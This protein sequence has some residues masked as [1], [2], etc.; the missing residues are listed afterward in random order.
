VLVP[1]ARVEPRD[2]RIHE[3]AFLHQDAALL[4]APQRLVEEAAIHPR[5]AQATRE[6]DERRLVRRAVGQREADEAPEAQPILQAL[7]ELL[8]AEPEPLRLHHAT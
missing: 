6:H 7:L 2:A 1:S 8:I 4:H 3:R 5:L